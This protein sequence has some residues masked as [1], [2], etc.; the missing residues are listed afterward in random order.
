LDAAESG[1][2][3]PPVFVLVGPLTVS[4][5]VAGHEDPASGVGEVVLGVLLSG[6]EAVNPGERARD[7]D[8]RGNEGPAGKALAL[9]IGH[10]PGR[11]EETTDGQ[12]VDVVERDYVLWSVTH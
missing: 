10:D 11:T 9:P 6:D 2:D 4:G 5:K 7:V 8:L 3:R 12:E 1:A